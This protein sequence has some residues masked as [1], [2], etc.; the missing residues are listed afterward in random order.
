MQIQGHSS[1][2]QSRLPWLVTGAALVVYLLTLNRWVSLSSL[3]VV[4]GVGSKELTPPI[5]EPLHFLVFLPFR[6]L[7]WK[8]R[9]EPTI[10]QLG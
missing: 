4:A 8:T 9:A 3:P 1:F 6:W 7:L 10:E 5:S 2:A